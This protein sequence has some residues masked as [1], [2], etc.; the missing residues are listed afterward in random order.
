MSHV[1]VLVVGDEVGRLASSFDTMLAAL[2]DSLTAQRQ[3]VADA[4]HELRTPLTS[5]TTNLDLLEDG[6]GLADPQAPA[7]VRAAR[8]GHRRRGPA[9]HLRALLPGARRPRH[10]GRGA[11]ASDRRR[12]RASQPRHRRRTHRAAR[13]DVHARVH[14]AAN[15]LRSPGGGL[16]M[17]QSAAYA[18]NESRPVMTLGPCAI[19][20]CSA[21]RWRDYPRSSSGTGRVRVQYDRKLD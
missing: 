17:T 7:L 13:V 6:A 10:A 9:V 5:L 16:K 19:V 18:T 11:G 1:R 4:S 2:H 8:H 21:G 20:L 12:C 14:P 3:L 15:S